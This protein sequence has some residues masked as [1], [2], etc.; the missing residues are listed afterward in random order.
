MQLRRGLLDD[1]PLETLQRLSILVASQQ[2]LNLQTIIEFRVEG[3][4]ETHLAR[5]SPS[6]KSTC[7]ST[8]L[9]RIVM[10]SPNNSA[11]T[12]SAKNP[13]NLSPQDRT[14]TTEWIGGKCPV[15]A[16]AYPHTSR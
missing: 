13:T 3:K 2:Q 7:Q 12:G 8:W 10:A 11:F 5:P 16:C 15:P 6:S 1:N 4:G 14:R 9:L